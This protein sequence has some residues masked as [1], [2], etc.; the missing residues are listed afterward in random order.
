MS[1]ESALTHVL[2]AFR[3]SERDNVRLALVDGG[4][5]RVSDL[6]EFTFGDFSQLEHT[7]PAASDTEVGGSKQA[8]E[9]FAKKKII[10]DPSVVPRTGRA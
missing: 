6:K 8:F 2:T 1:E 5:E 10:T 9:Y 4:T 3:Q 7:Q